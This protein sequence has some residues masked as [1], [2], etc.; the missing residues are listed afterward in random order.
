MRFKLVE[1]TAK[2]QGIKDGYDNWM[3]GGVK[4]NKSEFKGQDLKDYEDGFYEGQISAN[5]DEE[6]SAGIN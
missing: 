2:E 4:F 6:F 3:Y 5:R 1:M